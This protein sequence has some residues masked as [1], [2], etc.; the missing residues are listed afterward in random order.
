MNSSD[1]SRLL[2]LLDGFEALSDLS[3]QCSSSEKDQVLTLYRVLT[4]EYRHLVDDLD[5]KG[6]LPEVVL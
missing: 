5:V 1:I 3:I 6:L 2:A 4:I